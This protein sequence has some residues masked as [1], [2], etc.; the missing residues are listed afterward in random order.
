MPGLQKQVASPHNVLNIEKLQPC[1]YFIEVRTGEK[2][3][4]KELVKQ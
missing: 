4:I 3:M 2:A 1:V